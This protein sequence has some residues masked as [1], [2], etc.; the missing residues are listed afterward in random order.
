MQIGGRP[1]GSVLQHLVG[2]AEGRI[3]VL[4]AP[5]NSAPPAA[6]TP[7]LTSRWR[8]YTARPSCRAAGYVEVASQL[9]NRQPTIGRIRNF[10]QTK[11][12]REP[13][14]QIASLRLTS[15]MTF[16]RFPQLSA[17]GGRPAC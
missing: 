11:P 16:E 13:Q 3:F 12:Q 5:P 8:R 14:R 1:L 6:R 4:G 9:V 17:S 7:G 2:V 15:L 10:L